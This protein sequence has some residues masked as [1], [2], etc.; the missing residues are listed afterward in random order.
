MCV[1]HECSCMQ[2]SVYTYMHMCVHAYGRVSM[3]ACVCVCVCVRVRVY[4]VTCVMGCLLSTFIFQD[5]FLC[6][7]LAILELTL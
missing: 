7:A 6:V 4:D 5:R 2:M 3:N 1:V